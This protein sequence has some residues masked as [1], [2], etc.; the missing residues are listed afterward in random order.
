[1]MTDVM[2]FVCFTTAI[3][4]LFG[5]VLLV[6]GTPPPFEALPEGFMNPAANLRSN[7]GLMF[8]FVLA[9]IVAPELWQRMSATRTPEDARR[10]ALTAGVVLMMLYALVIATGML[11]VN[12]L[13]PSDPMAQK[14]VLLSLAMMLPSPMLTAAVLVGVLSAVTST[15]DSALN[16]GTLTFTRDIMHRHI[17]TSA[18]NRQLVNMSRV[19]TTFIGL[20]AV[21]IALYYQDIIKVLW[22]S[23]DIYASTMFVPI[24]GLFF[25]RNSGRM[26]GILGMSFGFVPVLFSFLRD[27]HMLTLPGWWPA[28]PFTTL[29]GVSCS[30][31]GFCLGAFLHHLSR[32]KSVEPPVEEPLTVET[33]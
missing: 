7:L 28:W 32:R 13:A 30:L 29:L 12:H 6:P 19:C 10:S 17:W 20:P 1:V 18:S 15:I 31:L 21:V 14:N 16:V 33:V 3:L 11:A 23:A 2:Q 24:M 27:F 25:A 4:I 5:F 8:T 9:W 22:I 26:A